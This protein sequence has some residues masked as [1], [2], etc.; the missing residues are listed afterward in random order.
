MA[1]LILIL[2]TPKGPSLFLDGSKHVNMK[3]TVQIA[4]VK[5]HLSNLFKRGLP[6]EAYLFRETLYAP[7]RLLFFFLNLKIPF[8]LGPCHH[9]LVILCS[10]VYYVKI[11]I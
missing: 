8:K 10:K 3:Q 5:L 11:I 4:I 7:D 2:K 6:H 1:G 9:K